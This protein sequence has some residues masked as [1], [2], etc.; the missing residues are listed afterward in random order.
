VIVIEA[1]QRE[2]IPEG[3]QADLIRWLLEY[4]ERIEK[5]EKIQVTFDLAG[6]RIHAS[7]RQNYKVK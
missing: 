6:E 5:A 7:I 4:R 1:G 3:R 2:H